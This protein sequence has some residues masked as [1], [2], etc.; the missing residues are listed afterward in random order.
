MWFISCLEYVAIFI[1]YCN[2]FTWSDLNSKSFT[3]T[4]GGFGGRSPHKQSSNPPNWNIKQNKSVEFLSKLSA[5]PPLHKRKVRPHICKAPLLMTFWRRFCFH[6]DIRCKVANH[7]E[8]FYPLF[9]G[10]RN[11]G[12]SRGSKRVEENENFENKK[13]LLIMPVFVQ[14]H[15]WPQ[16]SQQKLW[17]TILKYLG[18][19]KAA[20]NMFQVDLDKPWNYQWYSHIKAPPPPLPFLRKIRR[21]MPT[22]C[23]LSPASLLFTV[24]TINGNGKKIRFIWFLAQF[25]SNNRSNV[26]KNYWFTFFNAMANLGSIFFKTSLGVAIRTFKRHSVNSSMIRKSNFFRCWEWRLIRMSSFEE[27]CHTRWRHGCLNTRVVF[28]G[29]QVVVNRTSDMAISKNR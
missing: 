9:Q 2:S 23:L 15:C 18:V 5:K 11:S 3:F 1:K 21:A 14:R 12:R 20:I 28:F 16:N 13:S 25:S 8:Q 22:S 29:F 27:V 24:R 19:R 4:Q 10:R 26:F 7:N 6:T 17:K